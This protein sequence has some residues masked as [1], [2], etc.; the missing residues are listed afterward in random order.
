[1]TQQPLFKPP[2]PEPQKLTDRQ[3]AALT[4]LQDAGSQ[5]LHGRD[6]GRLI[7]GHPEG[8][9]FCQS[10]GMELLGALKKKGH[11]RET[12]GKVFVAIQLPSEPITDQDIP[13]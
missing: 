5:G 2:T 9:R 10:A 3:A 7:H 6:L 11:A 1:M 4:F 13:F 8:C 12:K